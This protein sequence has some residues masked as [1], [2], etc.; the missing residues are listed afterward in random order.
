MKTMLAAR[1][2]VATGEVRLEEVEVPEPAPHEARL[3]VQYAGI[4]ASDLHFI[5]GDRPAGMPDRLTLG[6][7]VAGVIDKLGSPSPLWKEGDRVAVYAMSGSGAA[8]RIMGVHYDGGWAEYVKVSTDALVPIAADVSSDVAAI[9]PDAV[10]TPW[11][12]ITETARIRP[13]ESAAVWGVG[14]LGFHA[15]LLL[16]LVGAAPVIAVDPL[17]PARDRAVRAGADYALDPLDSEFE[18]R[19]RE[20]VGGPGLDAAFDFFGAPSVQQQAFDAVGA[21]GRLVMVGI[22]R[23]PLHLPDASLVVRHSKR[24]LGHYGLDRRHI[25][26]ILKLL[27]YERLDL[28]ASIS[29]V[30]PL[31]EVHQ[32]LDRLTSKSGGPIRILLQPSEN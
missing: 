9:V 20:I 3:R 7:E 11:A 4:C 1:L 31:S 18:N 25:E 32:A 30:Y 14:G 21:G 19:L 16:R 5:G 23:E 17:Q 28:S 10:T 13:G 29:G 15:V 2:A 26:E 22:G 12:A 27:Q 8:T 6:H 24:I